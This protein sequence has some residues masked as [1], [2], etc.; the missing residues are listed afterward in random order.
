MGNDVDEAL[1]GD[2]L[3]LMVFHSIPPDKSVNRMVRVRVNQVMSKVVGGPDGKLSIGG[4]CRR[5][6]AALREL[7]D[8]Y[9]CSTWTSFCS[10]AGPS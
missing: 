4:I 8:S 7:S 3:R 1:C 5:A 9:S 10:A 2:D 6:L